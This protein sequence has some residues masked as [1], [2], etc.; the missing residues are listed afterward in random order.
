MKRTGCIL[1]A[2]VAMLCLVGICRA[3][4]N[5]D[6]RLAKLQA[7]SKPGQSTQKNT[8]RAINAPTTA[9][10]ELH[11]KVKTLAERIDDLETRQKGMRDFDAGLDTRLA[12]LERKLEASKTQLQEQ[13]QK[14][15]EALYAK[16]AD[17]ERKVQDLEARPS[18]LTVQT[19]STPGVSESQDKTKPL[20]CE[21]SG[22]RH[23]VTEVGEPQ[24]RINVA[25]AQPNGLPTE[26]AAANLLDVAAV[27]DPDDN[28]IWN[29]ETL[30]NGF[31][32]LNDSL[33]DKGID[34]ALGLTNI[35]QQNNHGGISTHRRQGRHT[36][37]Y[38][39]E[40]SSDLQKLL[41][42]EGGT[43]YVH[44]EGSWSRTDIDAT[45]VGSVFG[46][47]A[48]AAGRRAMDV[49]EVWYEQAVFDQSLLIRLGK[50]DITG[51]FEC[52]GCPVSFD[53]SLFANDETA[54]FLNGAL[55]NNPTIP[56]PDRGL[57]AIIHW[58][59]V[60][61]W[62][63]SVGAIDAQADA[64]ETGFATAFHKEDYFFYVAETG[65]T[66][67]LSSANGP[68]QGAY[69]VGVWND[70]QPKANSDATKSYRDD[71]GLYL[72]CDQ[73]LCKESRD[74]EDTQGLGA[75]FRYG[76]ADDRKNNISDF[77]STGFQYQGLLDGRDDDVLGV[78]F[79]QGV[80]SNKAS[81]TYA[82]DYES[83]FEAYYNVQVSPWWN[84]SP[85]LQYIANPGGAGAASD[86]VV[87]G[88]RSQMAF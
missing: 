13:T 11:L 29:R 80:F 56:F 16:L 30:T 84:V 69:R 42:V 49:T 9:A 43:L 3:G 54:Q 77:W 39:L 14:A 52:R 48:D 45:S 40:I 18:A 26:P 15:H 78:G 12:E 66:P 50:L 60:E 17:L 10:E 87:V 34:V 85:S 72:S 75:F 35:Y 1:L 53:G 74:A 70:P 55:V 23:L 57:G 24:N 81:T 64:R 58:N 62:Y 32:G 7:A 61:S 47:N 51:G 6:A 73:M 41:G 31:G 28:D 65:I 27:P 37:S 19:P 22:Q 25:E 68:L 82:A 59:P 44:T 76:L 36:G 46:V 20:S 38:D 4:D 63:A 71:V 5:L 88:V 79:A 86:A 83:A 2:V 33:A 8:T 67:Q 21:T